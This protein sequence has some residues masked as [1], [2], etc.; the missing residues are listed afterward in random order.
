[1]SDHS[2]RT[3]SQLVLPEEFG[4]VHFGISPLRA[5]RQEIRRNLQTDL[6]AGS[7]EVYTSPN[8]GIGGDESD[9]EL[10]LSPSKPRPPK[11]Q[12]LSQQPGFPPEADE[13]QCKRLKQDHYDGGCLELG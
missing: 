8:V 12:P 13:R 2:K 1:M 6:P 4:E 5:A 9:D 3:R 10:L 11:R 7:S